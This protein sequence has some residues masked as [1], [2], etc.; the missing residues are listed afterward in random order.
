[1]SELAVF[2]EAIGESEYTNRISKAGFSLAGL[3]RADPEI[4]NEKISI[5]LCFAWDLVYGA[6][7]ELA[8]KIEP[9]MTKVGFGEHVQRLIDLKWCSVEKLAISKAKYL[10]VDL[11]IDE[12][13]ASR[14][15]AAAKKELDQ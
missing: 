13:D 10:A 11:K 3:A 8:R 12:A 1:M 5:G 7:A 15:I 9:F 6:R 2:M 4:L 14:L